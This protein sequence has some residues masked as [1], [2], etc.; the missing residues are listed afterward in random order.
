MLSDS[1]LSNVANEG[2]IIGSP[3][4][5]FLDLS[6]RYMKKRGVMVYVDYSESV[7]YNSHYKLSHRF[8]R[9]GKSYLRV[10]LKPPTDLFKYEEAVLSI[11]TSKRYAN[12]LPKCISVTI[13]DYL[14]WHGSILT[15]RH[16]ASVVHRSSERC[17]IDIHLNVEK[18]G[19][20][21]M[22]GLA[23]RFPPRHG[24]YVTHRIFI[25]KE[26]LLDSCKIS[27]VILFHKDSVSHYWLQ[28]MQLSSATDKEVSEL[29]RNFNDICYSPK[30]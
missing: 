20:S 23:K 29:P 16:L 10:K 2:K 22:F 1:S 9:P 15:L 8:L 6:E 7:K 28:S 3:W 21:T 18:K 26:K 25:P 4:E 14:K 24:G 5:G 19:K 11:L 27:I 12:G 30:A 17:Y 13:W